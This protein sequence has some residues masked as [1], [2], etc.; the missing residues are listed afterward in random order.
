MM[1]LGVGSVIFSPTA[2]LYVYSEF[3][4]PLLNH[5][6]NPETFLGST[7]SLDVFQGWLWPPQTSKTDSEIMT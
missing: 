6:P 4:F 7:Y 3:I 2:I 1:G 5:V